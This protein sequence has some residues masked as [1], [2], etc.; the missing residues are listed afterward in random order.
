MNPRVLLV[1]LVALAA[2]ALGTWYALAPRQAPEP[3]GGYVL[4]SPRPLPA[5]TLVD[6]QGRAFTEQ[7]FRGHWSMLYFGFTFC[8][9][10]CPNALSVMAQVKTELDA[11]EGLDDRYYLV[12][13]DPDRDTPERMAEYVTYFDPAFRGVT[14]DF[15]QLD[16]ITR[17]AGAVY[18]VPEAPEDEDYLVAHSSTLTV[19]DPQGRIHAIFTSPFRPDA[20]ARD[21]ER[22]GASWSDTGP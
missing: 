1:V 19:I 14:G 5:F 8:P 7:N 10:I 20:I 16:I 17:A 21:F 9:D 22:L 3:T 18:K 2:F 4:D 12:S 11:V 6:E 15:E 13:V